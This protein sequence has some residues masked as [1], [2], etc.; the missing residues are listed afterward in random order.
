[1]TDKEKIDPLKWAF[2]IIRD[3]HVHRL[4]K[5]RSAR[6]ISYDSGLYGAGDLRIELTAQWRYVISEGDTI[7]DSGVQE[8]LKP[9]GAM[10]P[11]SNLRNSMILNTE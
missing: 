9:C 1:M 6:L 11:S 8:L 5:G 10:H 2:P 7:K 4:S 3:L